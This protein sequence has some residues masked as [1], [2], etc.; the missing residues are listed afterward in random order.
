[1]TYHSMHCGLMIVSRVAT[2][3]AGG[4]RPSYFPLGLP[5][6]RVLCSSLTHLRH[7]RWTP[8]AVGRGTITPSEL[9]RGVATR[10]ALRGHLLPRC[11]PDARQALGNHNDGILKM[12]SMVPFIIIYFR[13]FCIILVNLP[14]PVILISLWPDATQSCVSF[15]PRLPRFRRPTGQGWNGEDLE[16]DGFL[17]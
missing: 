2:R 15:L 9:P 6:P 7:F 12:T 4:L 10:D 17:A 5:M 3:R 1:M 11:S 13:I 14:I 8:D 16:Q